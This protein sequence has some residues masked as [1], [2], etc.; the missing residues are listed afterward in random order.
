[1]DG[2][3]AALIAGIFGIIMGLIEVI[4]SMIPK[5]RKSNGH[6]T[7]TDRFR[8]KTVHTDMKR[9]NDIHTEL[10]VHTELFKQVLKRGD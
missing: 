10:V 2:G 3:D 7:E 4:K 5:M 8:L 9:L 6:F 1:M